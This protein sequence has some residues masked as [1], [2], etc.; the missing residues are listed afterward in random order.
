MGHHL[1]AEIPGF[2]DSYGLISEDPAT[3]IAIVFVHGFWGDSYSTWQD[4]QILVDEFGQIFPLFTESD[5]FFL[6][7]D[8][9]RN[10][11][12]PSADKLHH[13]VDRLFPNPPASLFSED[14]SAADWGSELHVGPVSI[15][16]GPYVYNSLILVGHSLGAVVVR[17]MIL[18]VATDFSE[19]CSIAPD[20]KQEFLAQRPVLLADLRLMSPAHLGFRPVGLLGAA[21][22]LAPMAGLLR[23]LLSFYRSFTEL[24]PNSALLQSLRRRTEEISRSFPGLPALCAKSLFAQYDD[25]VIMDRYD[26]DRRVQYVADRTHTTI[27]KP[28]RMYLTPLEFI[29]EYGQT[30]EQA[31]RA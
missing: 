1:V 23:G 30:Y 8:A 19:A 12:G 25:L 5:L 15:R 4:T 26:C 24:D 14:V 21:F 29:A 22:S 27:C 20:K 6:E 28:L 16:T 2:E 31:R 18:D 17:Q 10:F 3:A 13:F 7:Y 9:A 11:I